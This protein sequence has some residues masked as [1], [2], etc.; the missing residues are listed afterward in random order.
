MGT[1]KMKMVLQYQGSSYKSRAI[2]NTSKNNYNTRN[3]T[4]GGL[5][6]LNQICAQSDLAV[7]I[8]QELVLTVDATN[9]DSA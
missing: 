6:L 7:V 8:N 4:P 5:A 2:A 1:S 3:L 9:N